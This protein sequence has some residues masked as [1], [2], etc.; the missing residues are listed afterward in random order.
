MALSTR[1]KFHLSA[2]QGVVGLRLLMDA[3]DGVISS[4]IFGESATRRGPLIL[5]R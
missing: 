2:R 3:E 1:I 5:T 4:F